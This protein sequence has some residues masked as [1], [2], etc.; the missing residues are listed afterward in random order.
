M[1]DLIAVYNESRIVN[2]KNPKLVLPHF[3]QHERWQYQ[4]LER[5]TLHLANCITN[6][7]YP[8]R[9]PIYPII[10]LES[11]VELKIGH[12]IVEPK[13]A[14]KAVYHLLDDYVLPKEQQRYRFTPYQA[15]AI[16]QAAIDLNLAKDFDIAYVERVIQQVERGSY[17]S[18]IEKRRVVSA[19]VDGRIAIARA[20][21]Q[22]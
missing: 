22:K 10:D 2:K 21:T 14:L 20:K 5:L 15:I 11:I 19:L 16:I 4:D 13:S 7:I 6:G 17:G 18:L 8:S 3:L 12:G 1:S 9:E